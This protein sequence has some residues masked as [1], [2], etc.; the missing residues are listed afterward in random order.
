MSRHIAIIVEGRVR[1]INYWDSIR[2]IF[3]PANEFVFVPLP[4]EANLYMIWKQMKK[5]DFNTDI[6][7]IIKEKSDEA[8]KQLSDYSRDSFQEKYLFFDYDPHQ[9]NISSDCEQDAVSVLSEMLTVFNN[10]TELGKLYISY[11]MCEALRDVQK[12]SCIPIS[13]CRISFANLSGKQYKNMTGN[14]NPF[15]DSRK[16]SIETWNMFISIFIKRCVCL[17][18]KDLS[19]EELIKWAKSEISPCNL[20]VKER[21]LFSCTQ[22]VFVLSAFPEFI[23]D[24]FSVNSLEKK[25]ICAKQISDVGCAY[26]S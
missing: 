20:L 25:G 11:P 10:E 22:E 9:N 16:Y 18:N 19:Q 24:Y 8:K 1:E 5:D 3:F 2:R 12:D 13:G 26:V 21:E 14:N 6:I 23:I 17:Y 7:E 4:A 15:A